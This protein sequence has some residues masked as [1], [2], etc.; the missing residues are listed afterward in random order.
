MRSKNFKAPTTVILCIFLY[1]SVPLP[2]IHNLYQRYIIYTKDTQ[3]YTKAG[4]FPIGRIF[5]MEAGVRGSQKENLYTWML[6]GN[7]PDN[8]T[9]NAVFFLEKNGL[10]CPIGVQLKIA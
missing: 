1:L 6:P 5:K 4:L 9:T 10:R 8:W 2:K 3:R 7:P